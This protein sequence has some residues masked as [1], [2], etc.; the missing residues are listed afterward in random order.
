[1]CA[2]RLRA[3]AALAAAILPPCLWFQQALAGNS[4]ENGRATTLVSDSFDGYLASQREKD[5]L[6]LVMFHVGWCKVCQKTLPKFVAA[7]DLIFEQGVAMD[8]AHVDCTNDK[9]LCKRFDV[10]GYPTIKLF[11]LQAD[12]EPTSY[13]SQRNA[14]GFLKYAQRMTQPAVRQIAN[15]SELQELLGGETFAAFVAAGDPA[16][17]PVG[18]AAAADTWRDRHIFAVAPRLADLLPDGVAVPPGASLAVLSAGAQQWPGADK[19]A[20]VSPAALFFEGDIGNASAVNAWVERSRFPG[21][22]AL[23]ESNFYAFT[24]AARR[25]AMLA[26]DPSELSLSEEQF[27]RSAAAKLGDDFIFGVLDGVSWADELSDFNIASRELPRVLIAEQEFEAW[28]EDVD[29]LRL[30][31]LEEDLRGFLSGKKQILRQ[32]RSAFAKIMF[33]KREA[34]RYM[35]L[36]HSYSEKGPMEA[37]LALC[38]VIAG[39]FAVM[40]AGW[41]AMSCCNILLSDEMDTDIAPAKARRPK[42]D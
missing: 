9:S 16:A 5:R 29:E 10:K 12:S 28:Y 19:T 14:E 2:V 24:H 27:L 31:T 33:Y 21:V 36:L 37:V 23:G 34:W 6:S 17:P 8:F 30:E 3:A 11:P 32:G 4:E 38:M 18:F 7:A 22:W 39:T 42:K 35:V 15:A 25:A 41:V 40:A 26:V 20:E 13:R 1:M